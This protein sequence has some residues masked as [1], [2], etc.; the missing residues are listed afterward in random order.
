MIVT[1]SN[2]DS[3]GHNPNGTVWFTDGSSRLWKYD[4]SSWT[5]VLSAAGYQWAVAVDPADGKN[6]TVVGPNSAGNFSHDGGVTWS[7]QDNGTRHGRTATDIPW[8]ANTNENYMTAGNIEYD[9]SQSNVLFL[10]QGIGVWISNPPAS[11]YANSYNSQSAGIE[12]LVSQWIVSP[13]GASSHPIFTAWDRPVWEITNPDVYPSNHGPNYAHAIELGHSVDW[14][15]G[16]PAAVAVIAD[17]DAQESSVS[18]R[19]GDPLSWTKFAGQPSTVTGGGTIAMTSA[20]TWLWEQGGGHGDLYRTTD[21]GSHWTQINVP[22]IPT[23]PNVT[24]WASLFG[25]YVNVQT[26]AADRVNVG[27][28]YAYNTGGGGANSQSEGIWVTNDSGSTWRQYAHG[29][30]K[31]IIVNGVAAKMRSVPGQAGHVFFSSG[32]E[33]GAVHPTEQI[34][35]RSFDGGQTWLD[36]SS[37][38]N[39]IRDVWSFGF[40]APNP[41]GDGYPAIYIY[42]WINNVGGLWRSDDNCTTWVRLSGLQ[43]NNSWDTVRVVE[44]DANVFGMVY[45]GFGGSGF[46]Y[47]RLK[48]N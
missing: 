6:V 31:P 34:F 48:R 9:P 47:G 39:R 29:V 24:G 16:A 36:I 45:V 35:Y 10:S 21:G 11:G 38:S 7:G 5:N 42:G 14:A 46:A 28:F 3:S 37:A 27:T 8:L 32:V 43:V 13:W 23:N 44:G 12:Q 2:T 4:G 30:L 33:E 1:N 40:G 25:P 19:A 22:G 17:G 20:T 41:R 15:A 26:L 18:K